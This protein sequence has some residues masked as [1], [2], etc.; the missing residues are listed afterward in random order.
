M[1]FNW[2]TAIAVF[3][4]LAG[5]AGTIIT[6]IFG[7]SLANEIQAALMAISGAL[8]AITGYHATS[9]VATKAKTANALKLNATFKAPGAN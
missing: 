8:I 4:A 9:V 1:T 2:A 5:V 3:T 6:P 7:T